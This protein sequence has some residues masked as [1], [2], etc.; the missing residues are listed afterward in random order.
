MAKTPSKGSAD[1]PLSKSTATPPQNIYYY[2]KAG[3][4]CLALFAAVAIFAFVCKELVLNYFLLLIP[5]AMTTPWLIRAALSVL[6]LGVMTG[7]VAVCIRPLWMAMIV[8]LLAAATYPLIMGSTPTIWLA[9]ALL[10]LFFIGYLFSVNR[11]LKN[12]IKFSIHALSDG[13]VLLFSAFA[14]LMSF[15]FALGYTRDAAIRSY[16]VPPEIKTEIVSQIT[17]N[18]DKSIDEGKAAPQ[19]KMLAKESAR[20]S[21]EEL[22]NNYEN[23]IKPHAASIPVIL[24]IVSFSLF[25]F[26]FW[27]VAF[28]TLLLL[29]LLFLILQKTGFIHMATEMREV[30]QPTLRD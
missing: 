4:C 29:K 18:I 21:I 16:V 15:A 28:I 27:A 6:F 8:Y 20:K 22:I 17:T 3:L 1:T 5:G 14:V 12:Q 13:K 10:A 26:E 7:I 24:G 23:L 19:Q 2:L 9:A 25:F 30:K 11:L